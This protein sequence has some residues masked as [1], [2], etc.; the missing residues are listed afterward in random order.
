[1]GLSKR[2]VQCDEVE[3][4]TSS[5]SV[6][7]AQALNTTTAAPS[8]DLSEQ[9]RKKSLMNLLG[10]SRVSEATLQVWR[11]LP[12]EIRHDPSMINFQREAERWKGEI[13]FCICVTKF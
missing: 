13:F 6:A 5:S 9:R 8:V 12:G 1:M 2:I 4:S 10:K 3:T 11:N 7:A